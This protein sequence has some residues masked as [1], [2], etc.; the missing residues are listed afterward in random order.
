MPADSDAPN[1]ASDLRALATALDVVP[2]RLSGL[3]SARPTASTIPAGTIHQSTDS[4]VFSL[5]TG[6]AWQAIT[7]GPWTALTLAGGVTASG[8]DTPKARQEGDVIR[9]K[10]TATRTSGAP[11]TFGNMPAGMFSTTR[12]ITLTLTKALTGSTTAVLATISTSGNILVWVAV[13]EVVYLDDHTF[14]LS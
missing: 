13:G 2:K 10:G 7:P 5:C 1:V 8:G 9:L 4:G 3:A 14:T 6:A 12:V 11:P